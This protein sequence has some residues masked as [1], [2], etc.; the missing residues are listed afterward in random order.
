M[1]WVFTVT[2]PSGLTKTASIRNAEFNDAD[3]REFRQARGTTEA[4]LVYV[5][6][7][8]DDDQFIEASWGFL[9]PIERAALEDFFGREGTLRQTRAFNIDISGSSFP[10]KLK[11]KM[12]ISGKI[13]Q[14][15]ST[16]KAGA[17]VTPDTTNLRNVFLDQPDLLFAQER[18]ERF[19]L[20]LR[21][22]IHRPVG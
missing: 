11:A 3:R 19:S 9:T 10:Q 20:D 17:T 14:A 16:F 13:V 18:D 5:Q 12:V 1:A 6:D 8:D 4:G 21:F 22:R 2:P 7:L 15:G